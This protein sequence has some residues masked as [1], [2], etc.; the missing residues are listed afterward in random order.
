MRKHYMGRGFTL[1]E[2]LVVIAIIAVLI[3]LLL[4]AVQQARE[5]ARR[6]E[7]RNHLKQIGLA[8]HNYHDAHRVFPIGAFFSDRGGLQFAWGW[9]VF[10]LPY[11]DQANFYNSLNLQS[12]TYPAGGSYSPEASGGN[13]FKWK[14]YIPAYN[15]PSDVGARERDIGTGSTGRMIW[16]KVCYAAM[17][18]SD[19]RV[20]PDGYTTYDGNGLFYNFSRHSMR[21]ILD[22]SSNTIAAG[23]VS[24]GVPT[25]AASLDHPSYL[26]KEQIWLYGHASLIDASDPINGAGTIPGNRG[27]FNPIEL[28]GQG[29][30]SYHEGGAHFAL[31]DG[32]VRFISE[33]VSFNIWQALA[34]RRGN[35]VL[36]EF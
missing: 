12:T 36:G 9:S 24:N 20:R 13:E 3:A 2:L 11:I 33:N 14:H 34:T 26:D 4:P 35:E 1:I 29:S 25:N 30:S 21:D 17:A 32:S 31:G 6:T 15:C 19:N 18:G 7:C 23:E 8:L 22:G 5:A 27:W 28:S 16:A 10:I